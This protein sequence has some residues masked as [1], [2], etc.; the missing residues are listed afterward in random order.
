MENLKDVT[1]YLRHYGEA[2]AFE[3]RGGLV[4]VVDPYLKFKAV[5]PFTPDELKAALD[6]G[7]VIP[8]SAASLDSHREVYRLAGLEERHAGVSGQ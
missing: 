2:H 7:Y 8:V 4:V 5:T 3:V 6:A 1:E